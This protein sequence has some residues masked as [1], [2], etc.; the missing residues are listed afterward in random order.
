MVELLPLNNE[1][2]IAMERSFSVGVPGTGNSIKLYTV[3]L[4]GAT[5]VNGVD[6]LAGKLDR[7]RP[8]RKTLLL[9]FSPRCPY[10]TKNMPNWNAL[11]LGL[12]EKEV[13]GNVIT[14]LT[15]NQMIAPSYW[16]DPKSGNDYLLTVL[17]VILYF[18]Y[19]GIAWN[20]LMGFAGQLSLGHAL[21]VGLGA[22]TTAA[23]FVH[24]GIGPWVGMPIA[25]LI[26]VVS[27]MIIG[28]LAFRFGVAGVYFA[29]LTI[30]FCEFARV[31][32][33]HFGWVSGSSGL[34]LPVASR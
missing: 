33:D 2:L 28:F 13:V 14:A 1:F 16:V 23:L 20:V 7:I 4:P 19:T 11:T 18:A 12:N 15:S 25:I 32:F 9:V 6:S 24:F 10:C 3:A 31:G 27:G 21:Y 8:A 5:D 17:I 30:A 34:F 26:S 22:Y 29:I